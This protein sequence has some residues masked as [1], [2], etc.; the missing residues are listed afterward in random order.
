MRLYDEQV[1]GGDVVRNYIRI[2]NV[3]LE[4]EYRKVFYNVSNVVLNKQG[5]PVSNFGNITGRRRK[6]CIINVQNDWN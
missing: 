1:N 2:A 5:V 4:E 6:V 3:W